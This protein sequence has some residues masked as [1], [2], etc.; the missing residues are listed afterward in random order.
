MIWADSVC[1]RGF[2]STRSAL[3]SVRAFRSLLYVEFMLI[4]VNVDKQRTC[5][6]HEHMLL[7]FKLLFK[8]KKKDIFHPVFRHWHNNVGD[9]T[10][11]MTDY[12]NANISSISIINMLFDI[13]RICCLACDTLQCSYLTKFKTTLKCCL[14]YKFVYFAISLALRLSFWKQNGE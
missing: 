10:D 1:S 5:S 13:C 4:F 8:K 6:L 11:W 7:F 2:C 9:V 14:S 3:S 12:F